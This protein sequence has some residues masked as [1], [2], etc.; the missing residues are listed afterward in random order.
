VQPNPR[1]T[2]ILKEIATTL[3][4]DNNNIR[5]AIFEMIFPIDMAIHNRYHTIETTVSYTSNTVI[6]R[7]SNI[8]AMGAL[9]HKRREKTLRCFSM[10]S[11][12]ED[13]KLFEEYVPLTCFFNMLNNL[14]AF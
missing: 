14:G 9:T 11:I 8:I 6:P 13:V 3:R 1:I 7:M 2:E 4:S 10:Y 5:S 12:K